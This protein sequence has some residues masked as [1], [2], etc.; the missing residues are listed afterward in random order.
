MQGQ[1]K[2]NLRVSI[3]DNQASDGAGLFDA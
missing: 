2:I 1:R 3:S